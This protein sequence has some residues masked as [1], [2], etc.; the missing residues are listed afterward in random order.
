MKGRIVEMI[1]PPGIGKTTLYKALC[2]TWR[3]VSQWT[4]PA[5]LLQQQPPITEGRKWLAYQFRKWVEK[6]T[7]KSIPVTYGMRFI[8]LHPE[9]AS[10][11]WQ[12]LS[13]KEVYAEDQIAMRFRAAHFLFTD[14]CRY[15]AINE[16][17]DV[18]PCI[19]SE[20]LL[21][22]SFFTHYERPFL[23]AL[24]EKYISLLPLP[25]AVIYINSGDK[26]L[27]IKRLRQREK[28]IPSHFG[29]DD[30]A[31][32]ADIETWNV[33]LDLMAAKLQE[34]NVPVYP[35]EGAKDV[36]ENIQTIQQLFKPDNHLLQ[37]VQA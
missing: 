21:Q 14:F 32:L 34:R 28:I 31:L 30:A 36:S 19:I 2:K 29:K 16:H 17:K 5:V 35:I 22:K 24:I 12:Y 1:G 11:Y 7:S 10:F 6:D 13:C 37:L 3:P 9:L 33:V 20:G 8:E 15:Q 4:H 27:I 18:K 23:P 25:A 26:P